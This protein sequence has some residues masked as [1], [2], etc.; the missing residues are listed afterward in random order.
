[1]FRITA[2]LLLVVG[3]QLAGCALAPPAS[4]E[5]DAQAKTFAST[6]GKANLYIYRNEIFG[7]ATMMEVLL[8]GK[9]LGRTMAQQYFLI[10][11][12]P[13]RHTVTS[14]SENESTV[15]FTAVAGHNHFVWQEAKYG[16]LAPRTLMHVMSE[17][18]GRAGVGE[19]KRVQP[20][21]KQ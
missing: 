14:K 9:S 4:P 21:V 6:P 17:N 13:G 7:G 8:D 11:V 19:C 10:P 18:E 12:E 15:D 3:S 1:M 16:N 5:L 20:F 2:L